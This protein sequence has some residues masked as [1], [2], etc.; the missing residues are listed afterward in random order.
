MKYL[1]VSVSRFTHRSLLKLNKNSPT[2]LVTAGVVGFGATAVMAALATR[3][4]EPVLEQHSKD[5]A[6]IG[7]IPIVGSEGRREKQTEVLE[8]YF[9]TGLELTKIYAPALVT[10]T[11]ST[12][13]VLGGHKILKGRYVATMAAYSGLMEQ[14]SRY[15][16]R[17]SKTLGSDAER[18]IYNGAH[19]EW[20]EDPES[21]EG[22]GSLKPKFDENADSIAYLRPW[23][24]ETNVHWSR[25][26]EISYMFLKGV[27]NHMNDLLRI[28]GHVFLNEVLD[29]LRMPRSAE[30]QVTGWIYGNDRGDNFID[31]GFMSGTEPN[32][33]AF[34]NK[35]EK[36]VRL[37]FNVDGV[38]WDQI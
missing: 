10:G 1:P 4:I 13:S 19:G 3:K 31:F 16:D 23:F 18:D 30:G 29:A 26:P 11:L 5:R 33:V 28:R 38:V 15:R 32:T 9:H 34:R 14:F 6:E 17:V 21:K 12:A 25:D 2:L 8:L 22:G 37:N 35:V 36:T 27:Q 24:D 7:Y 20:V